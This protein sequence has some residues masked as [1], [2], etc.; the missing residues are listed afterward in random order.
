MQRIM[1]AWISFRIFKIQFPSVCHVR[2]NIYDIP[3]VEHLS[4][5]IGNVELHA[6]KSRDNTTNCN[7]AFS[8]CIEYSIKDDSSDSRMARIINHVPR[9]FV[10]RNQYNQL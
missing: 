8:L 4:P 10:E 1:F 3:P 6:I 9:T 2:E 7:H 5:Y